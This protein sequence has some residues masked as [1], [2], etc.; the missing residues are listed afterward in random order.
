MKDH[1]RYAKS[2]LG[3]ANQI[4]RTFHVT[5]VDSG[6]QTHV[7][8]FILNNYS[9]GDIYQKD[10]EEEL[11]IGRATVSFLLKKLEKN[12]MIVKEKVAKDERLKKIVPTESSIQLKEQIDSD[13]QVLESRL[14]S[15]IRKEELKIFGSVLD[16]MM[17]NM[18]SSRKRTVRRG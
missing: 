2:I 13:M 1:E 18:S 12:H 5:A 4:R 3:L 6:A 9:A 17:E 14:T 10:I 16:Q 15:G 11:H 8:Y 7:L